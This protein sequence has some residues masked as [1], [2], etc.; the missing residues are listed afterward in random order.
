METRRIWWWNFQK[1]S[2]NG[3]GKE[4]EVFRGALKESSSVI[5]KSC[6]WV[7]MQYIS[8]ID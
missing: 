6:Y 3:M 8:F 2:K 7:N 4:K 5:I 1:S